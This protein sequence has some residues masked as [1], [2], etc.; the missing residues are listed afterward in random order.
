[1][2]RK[3]GRRSRHILV[4]S[5]LLFIF[6]F[7]S[8]PLLAAGLSIQYTYDAAGRMNAATYIRNGADITQRYVYD[9]LGNILQ[10]NYN[11]AANFSASPT[12]GM[13]PLSVSFLDA[14]TGSITSW[15]WNFGDGAT[16]AEQ[17]PSHV[18]QNEG[19]YS[20]SLT[21]TGPSGNNTETKQNFIT[22]SAGLCTYSLSSSSQS[23]TSAGG[24]FSVLTNPSQPSCSPAISADVQWITINGYSAGTLNFTVAVNTDMSVRTGHISI[25]GQILTVTQ[26]GTQYQLSVT[27]SGNGTV[28]SSPSGI[29]CIS[30]SGVCGM[31]YASGTQV[32]LTPVASTGYVF[33]GWS[34]ACTGTGSCVVSMN[35]AQ[36]V[37]AVFSPQTFAVTATVGPSGGGSITP[38]STLVNSGSSL[39][40]S[41]VPDNG[42]TLSRL[43][44]NGAQ[45]SATPGPSGT[46]TYTIMN[47]TANHEV[48]A[49]FAESANW[50]QV[51]IQ[52]GPEGK[53]TFYGTVYYTSGSPD[54]SQLGYGGW[55]DAYYDFIEFDMT[56]APAANLVVTA[57]LFLYTPSAP[58]NDPG[59]TVNRIT[60]SW[61]EAGVTKTSNPT[62]AF[63]TTMDRI[64]TGWNVVD[65]TNLYK[66][67]KNNVY[68]NYG[69]K[70]VPQHTS[71]ANSIFYSSDYT[72]DPS[73]RPILV[74]ETNV[75]GN[76]FYRMLDAPGSTSTTLYG[77]GGNNILG[78]YV[79]AARIN[80][81]A[82]NGTNYTNINVPGS[83]GTYA[84][85]KDGNI[86]VGRY[87]NSDQ[88][89][90]YHGFIYDGVNYT[91][92]DIPGS[93]STSLYGISG[94]SIVGDYVDAQGIKGFVY[95]GTNYTIINVPGSDGTQAMGIYGNKIVGRYW[96]S[97]QPL[98]YHGFIYD[99]VNY[100]TLDVPGAT[101]TTPYGIS[102][103]KVVG[104]YY[105]GVRQSGFVYNGT[106]FTIIHFPGSYG[107]Q[108]MGI[109]GN[110]IVGRYYS[111][112]QPL[113]YHGFVAI[114]LAV[115][116]AGDF[117][118][119]GDVDGKDLAALIADPGLLDITTFAANFGKTGGQ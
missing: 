68:I 109:D 31:P 104:D 44:D 100:A 38:A 111:S 20:V 102:G 113:N 2:F 57:K 1:M 65:I 41:I 96:Y 119:D 3:A 56:N 62:S 11:C 95:D 30:G 58:P 61:T 46:F 66:D 97:D 48:L 74:I 118:G 75:V 99:G 92:L 15:S 21:V 34:G 73:L 35:A 83:A 27:V 82:Y 90:N 93:T 7:I 101:T 16:S 18:Y 10:F 115:P 81:F 103:N 53:D 80:G 72:D 13:S 45:V 42:F 106:N 70:L 107:T 79:D 108:A 40:L 25:A 12:S 98:N 59:L 14:S 117:A 87:F 63:Y 50:A 19:V 116:S 9:S 47:V 28:T 77:I 39:T 105:D 64:V 36:S 112:D 51:I 88:P 110:K 17:N 26:D 22:V 29:S 37:T 49:T 5:L 24:A 86:I 67:W 55:G 91:T 33:S 8:S 71:N 76:Y 32:T 89:L 60:Q 54:N 69:I 78:C 85:G 84:Y 114:P 4:G 23:V 52:P 43:T 94:N 6:L